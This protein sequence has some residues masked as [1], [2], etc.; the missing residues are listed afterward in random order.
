MI[1]PY[2]KP[3]A[4][5][6]GLAL[7]AVPLYRWYP[8][9]PNTEFRL[10][11]ELGRDVRADTWV[12]AIEQAC[13]QAVT[14]P[15]LVRIK[16]P[17]GDP[18]EGARIAAALADCARPVHT[19]IEQIGASAA[20]LPATAGGTVSADPYALVGGLGIVQPMTSFAPAAERLGIVDQTVASGSLK[21]L[22]SPLQTLAPEDRAVVQAVV[23][24]AALTFLADV[25]KRR[26]GF[27]PDE[28]IR[29][30]ALLTPQRAAAVGLIDTV[31][32]V[33][34]LKHRYPGPW[35]DATPARRTAPPSPWAA[36]AHALVQGIRAELIHPTNE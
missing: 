19:I 29:N 24:E 9:H 17:G 7:I 8:P 32:S 5:G 14:G 34:A 18:G 30:G 27:R 16:S 2:L 36:V 12:P 22:G 10:S 35:Q 11:G 4:V 21:L 3:I 15:I 25:Q 26:P 13:R 1:R 31:Q 28:D 23:D 6:I 20:M 33:D